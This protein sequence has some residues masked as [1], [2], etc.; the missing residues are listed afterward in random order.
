MDRT[1]TKVSTEAHPASDGTAAKAKKGGWLPKL[2]TPLTATIL[3]GILTVAGS[4]VGTFLQGRNSLQLEREKQQ[5]EL[6]L[7]MISIGDQKKA[8]ANLE[9]LAE[10]GL[11]ADQE[12]AKKILAKASP[13]LPPPSGT[14]VFRAGPQDAGKPCGPNNVGR[15]T[16]FGT[17]EY[18]P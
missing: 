3:A 11:I 18:A 17:C 6:V 4:V 16:P 12:L 15:V 8:K 10:T 13:V 1:T 7:K 14:L 2:P 5:H 9:F